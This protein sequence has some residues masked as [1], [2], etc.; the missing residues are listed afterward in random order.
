MFV[1]PGDLAFGEPFTLGRRWWRIG[2]LGDEVCCGCLGHTVHKHA[3]IGGLQ[4]NSEG[5][6]ESKQ[7]TFTI[8]EP[9]A[10]LLRSKLDATEVWL[11]L[12]RVSNI[13]SGKKQADTHQLPHQAPRC[14]VCVKESDDKRLGE[15]QSRTKNDCRGRG[16]NVAA[17]CVET[18]CRG[19]E[20]T[21]DGDHGQEINRQKHPHFLAVA[22][23]KGLEHLG[24]GS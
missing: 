20:S 10:L 13:L 21:N 24:L 23:S 12:G 17:E 5:K 19:H 14:K 3:D 22:I 15:N 8:T 18:G 1:L 7:H 16:A 6:G 11:Q 9:K 2:D 4:H